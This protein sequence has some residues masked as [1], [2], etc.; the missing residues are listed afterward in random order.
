[1]ARTFASLYG[2]RGIILAAL[3]IVALVLGI[4]HPGFAM[5]DGHG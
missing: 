5:A 4:M 1:V 2:R 3:L